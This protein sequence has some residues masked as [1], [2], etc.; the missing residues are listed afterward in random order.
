VDC[1]SED[2][3]QLLVRGELSVVESRT[4]QEHLDGCITCR[5][6]LGTL[7]RASLIGEVGRAGTSTDGRSIGVD[8][9]EAAAFAPGTT[10]GRYVVLE[11]LGVG[12]MGV[13]LLARDPELDRQVAL[14]LIRPAA[15]AEHGD[16]LRE[17]LRREARAMAR[18]SH[19]N[20]VTVYDVGQFGDEVIFVA[21]EYV[22]GRNVR[23]W[24]KA[25]PRTW[26]EVLDVFVRAGRGLAAAHAA[27]LVHRDF[28]PDNVLV[29]DDGSVRVADFGL[30]RIESVLAEPLP[31]AEAHHLVRAHATTT[32][33]SVFMGTPAYMAPEVFASGRADA[34][35]DQ[36][37]FCVSLYEAL[38]GQR[39]FA[40]A[41]PGSALEIRDPPRG[42]TVPAWVRRPLLQGMRARPEAR[43]ASMEALLGDL[44]RDP[45]RHR[46]WLAPAV[47]SLLA[48]AA[49]I[50]LRSPQRGEQ[51]TGEAP[52][53]DDGVPAASRT[54]DDFSSGDLS[55]AKWGLGEYQAVLRDGAAV[56]S[57]A[58]R[59]VQPFRVHATDLL[60][61]PPA[62]GQVTTF[63]SDV[64]L[65]SA[66]AT[67]D[68]SSGA[69]ID[70]WFQPP[71]NRLSFP[72]NTNHLIVI[73]VFLEL[74]ADQSLVA[75]YFINLCRDN[76]EDC[77]QGSHI[78]P[79]RPPRKVVPK[80]AQFGATWTEIVGA[81]TEGT[82]REVVPVSLGAR[83]TISIAVD[84]ARK[85]ITFAI[86]NRAGMNHVGSVDLSR[87]TTPFVPD[88]SARNFLWARLL[89]RMSGG[90]IG[91]GDGSV[92]ARFNDVKVGI[93]GGA[94]SLFDDFGTGSTFDSSRWAIGGKTARIDESGLQMTLDQRDVPAVAR[95]EMA[96]AS[97][98]A[99]Q[100]D[101][102]VKR[103][104]AAGTGRIAAQLREALYNDGS[105]GSGRAPD[106]NEPNSEVGDV[107]ASIYM[108]DREVFYAVERCDTAQCSRTGSG[109]TYVQPQTSL[110]KI[111][112][113]TTHTLYVNWDTARHRVL[114]RLDKGPVTSFDPLAAGSPIFSGPRIRSKRIA[115]VAT[116]SSPSDPFAHGSSGSMAATFAN[117]RTN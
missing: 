106:D 34:R 15:F 40:I 91:H 103:Y 98:S 16:A 50:V 92:S 81:R 5:E 93:D 21:M 65:E 23:Q 97:A 42:T 26:R 17:R 55:G 107:V 25:G 38:Y 78:G 63:Q 20:V 4:V 58:I 71:E 86:S 99:L 59:Q 1:L 70:V 12:G 14:K 30:A 109:F 112:P 51:P 104:S 46:K 35:S 27:G 39:P 37:S 32:A 53:A 36:F 64:V 41:R 10:V 74:Q 87:V 79:S 101:V 108:T 48:V 114:F 6:V 113:R 95:I 100:A 60:I 82:W 52:I 49:L 85:V 61:R 76:F 105:A 43:N 111:S 7:M 88:L 45:G 29:A 54:Y 24:L 28:K 115:I 2:T 68:T 44:S 33:S 18:L 77:S 110:G 8:L 80:L 57:H 116:S 13:V 67:G 66:T 83:Y 22:R 90:N 3:F 96:D 117:V 56:L 73:R 94:P 75:R 102:T 69:G 84:P 11:L 47:L 9:P 31:G 72:F 62:S 89:A 19:P